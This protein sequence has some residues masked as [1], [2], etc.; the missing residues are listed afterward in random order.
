MKPARIAA[1]GE[2]EFH[3]P[4]KANNRESIRINQSGQASP[5]LIIVKRFLIQFEQFFLDLRNAAV[6]HRAGKSTPTSIIPFVVKKRD[7]LVLAQTGTGMTSA[8]IN[9]RGKNA[10]KDNAKISCNQEP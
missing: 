5:W 9:A 2:N 8:L 4:V 7:I 6:I 1:T 10:D 3:P